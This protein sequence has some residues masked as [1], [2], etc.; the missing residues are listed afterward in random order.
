MISIHRRP[1]AAE[2]ECSTI[3]CPKSAKKSIEPIMPSRETKGSYSDVPWAMG[4]IEDVIS[5]R[6]YVRSFNDD[7][8]AVLRV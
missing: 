5:P 7:R 1:T 3:H 4:E 2:R 6:S 8:C